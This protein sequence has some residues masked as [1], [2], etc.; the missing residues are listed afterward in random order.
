MT[1]LPLRVCSWV[2]SSSCRS[3]TSPRSW[4]SAS[5]GMEEMSAITSTRGGGLAAGRSQ[6]GGL[7]FL[8][9]RQNGGRILRFGDDFFLGNHPLLILVEKETVQRDHAVLGAGLDVRID[10][11]GL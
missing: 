6:L 3:S 11:E 2:T 8:Q 9:F 5:N 7:H 1:G 10:A 4:I